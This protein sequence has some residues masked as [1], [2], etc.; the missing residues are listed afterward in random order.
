MIGG[1][2]TCPW[3]PTPQLIADEAPEYRCY[4]CNADVRFFKCPNC[5]LVQTVSKQWRMFTC[6]K[7]DTKQDLPFRWVTTERRRRCR[8]R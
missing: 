3:C 1:L 2:L 5:S 7:C 4:T 8:S 6:G